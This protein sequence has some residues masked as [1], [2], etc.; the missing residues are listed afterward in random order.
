[1]KS[2]NHPEKRK[3]G[4]FLTKSEALFMGKDPFTQ[5]ETP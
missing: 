5:Q 4:G 3:K 2:E 1:M